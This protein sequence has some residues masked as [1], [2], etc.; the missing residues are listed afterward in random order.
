MTVRDGHY[1]GEVACYA[2]GE[3]KARALRDLAEQRAYDLSESFAYSDSITDLPMLEAVGHPYAVNPD[4]GL[5]REAV[6]RGWPIL[7][8]TR[9]VSLR[10][11][12]PRLPSRPAVAAAALTAGAAAAGAVWYAAR[13][14]GTPETGTAARVD[15]RRHREHTIRRENRGRRAFPFRSK[16]STTDARVKESGRTS[17][18]PASRSAHGNRAPTRSSAL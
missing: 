16:R 6:R 4:R 14:R 15:T 7:V 12:L 8:F 17:L 5:R 18:P 3:E 1:T 10:A 9:P 13:R 2:F 11:R